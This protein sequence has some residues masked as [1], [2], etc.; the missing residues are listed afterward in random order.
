[1]VNRDGGQS[2]RWSILLWSIGTVV[3][4]DGGQSKRGQS[5]RGQLQRGQSG[6]WSILTWSNGTL[7]RRGPVVCGV[8]WRACWISSDLKHYIAFWSCVST[9]VLCWDAPTLV[10]ADSRPTGSRSHTAVITTSARYIG[11]LLSRLCAWWGAQG[12]FL[13]HHHSWP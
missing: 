1:M 5:Q 10:G 8:T 13:Y 11:L 4:Q 12:S 2:G 3:N 9:M 7:L 6:L